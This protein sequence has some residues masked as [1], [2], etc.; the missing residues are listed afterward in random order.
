MPLLVTFWPITTAASGKMFLMLAILAFLLF[1]YQKTLAMR[2]FEILRKF[3]EKNIQSS[4][5][6]YPYRAAS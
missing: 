1:N 5:V 4:L 6:P 2:K 3:V